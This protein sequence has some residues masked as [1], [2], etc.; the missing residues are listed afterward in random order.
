ME[1][2][3]NQ[4]GENPPQKKSLVNSIIVGALGAVSAVYLFNP[5]AGFIELIPDN[6]PI[7][8]NLDE[9][10]AA[11]LLISCLAYFGLD[12]GSLFGKAGKNP[13]AGSSKND[14]DVIDV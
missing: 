3:E 12:L 13:T 11:A 2:K 9:A 7:V 5:G 10:A 14:D 8:G 1:N 4:T 6:I